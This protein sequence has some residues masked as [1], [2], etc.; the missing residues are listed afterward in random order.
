MTEAMSPPDLTIV[1]KDSISVYCHQSII[2]GSSM[3]LKELLVGVSLKNGDDT[4]KVNDDATLYVPDIESRAVVGCLSLLYDG[5]AHLY[6]GAD[7]CNNTETKN[8]TL[9]LKD[10]W[11]NVFRIDLVKLSGKAGI[12]MQPLTGRVFR[13]FH[14]I[15]KDM[16]ERKTSLEVQEKEMVVQKKESDTVEEVN[17]F[18]DEKLLIKKVNNELEHL[19]KGVIVSENIPE[20]KTRTA[21]F[22]SP[23]PPS[24]HRKGINQRTRQKR[25]HPSQLEN[26]RKPVVE[27]K[28]RE[29]IVNVQSGK[30]GIDIE[31]EQLLIEKVTNELEHLDKGDIVSE[32]IPEQ[33]TRSVDFLSPTPPSMEE[34]K[35]MNLRSSK[36]RSYPTRLEERGEE[37][38]SIISPKTKKRKSEGSHL[39]FLEQSLGEPRSPTPKS[40]KNNEMSIEEQ[41]QKALEDVRAENLEFEKRKRK[42]NVEEKEVG[43][44]GQTKEKGYSE[45]DMKNIF[46]NKALLEAPAK[47]EEPLPKIQLKSTPLFSVEIAHCCVICDGKDKEGKVDKEAS[48]LSLS[49]PKRLKE[50]YC[51]HFYNEG[52]LFDLL[53]LE[54][55]N[56]KEDGS[57]LDE[58]GRQYRYKCDKKSVTRPG[59]PCWKSKKRPC[60]YKEIALH[61]AAEHGL[62]ETIIEADQRPEVQD[63]VRKLEQARSNL[64]K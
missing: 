46:R 60:G 3:F 55:A 48:N 49:D 33:I 13:D 4:L 6:T 28:E 51:R 25:F 47:P 9:E 5:V 10:L 45:S 24:L 26:D 34:K 62:F 35:R 8:N 20:Q 15:Q 16:K 54:E 7:N 59:E 39:S 57:I 18:E 12:D 1:C 21:D 41:L 53:P 40:S 52:K 43:K 30:A 36:K 29:P 61:H 42:Q 14:P 63:L 56:K 11:K 58:F 38:K 50:H 23:T 37:E 2:A 32:N 22:R 31:S 17:Y 64:S 44:Q 27:V 19:D